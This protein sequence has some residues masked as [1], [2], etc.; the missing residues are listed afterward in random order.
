[1]FQFD[2]QFSH[3]ALESRATAA[4]AGW[5]ILPTPLVAEFSRKQFAPS[6]TDV[7]DE[8]RLGVAW[9]RGLLQCIDPD[10]SSQGATPPNHPN[11]LSCWSQSSMNSCVLQALPIRAGSLR[12]VNAPSNLDPGRTDHGSPIPSAAR[13]SFARHQ[14]RRPPRRVCRYA[15]A[16][17]LAA[18]GPSIPAPAGDQQA[19]PDGAQTHRR[20]L[21]RRLQRPR[22]CRSQPLGLRC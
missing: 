14:L 21:P 17:S 19:R 5:L 18:A 1:V 6:S 8:D 13:C 16:G 15:R 2:S 9:C 3:L 12:E 7:L 4:K 20:R 10:G 11:N 22:H